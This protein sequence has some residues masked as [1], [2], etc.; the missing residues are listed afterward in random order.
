MP[1]R[2]IDTNVLVYLASGDPARADAAERAIADGGMVSVQVLNEFANVARR[3]LGFSWEELRSFLS[4]IQGL[5]SVVPVT[6]E[7]HD[8]GLQLAERYRLSVYDA[9]ILAA[10][11][12]N[13]CDLLLTEDLQTGL[14][15]EGLVVRNPLQPL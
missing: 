3:K 2:F 8:R 7:V 1:G 5:L 14:A 10:A 4:L 6:V 12:V 9:M 13:G 11:L 15:I